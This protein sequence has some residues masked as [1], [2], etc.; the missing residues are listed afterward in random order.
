MT[1]GVSFLDTVFTD[2]DRSV[3]TNVSTVKGILVGAKRTT[4][5]SFLE[6]VSRL[7][8][9]HGFGSHILHAVA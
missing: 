8:V 1:N 6:H 3:R 5:N 4:T 7:Y 9:A 2:C